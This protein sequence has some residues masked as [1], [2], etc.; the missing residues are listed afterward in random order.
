[1]TRSKIDGKGP[2]PAHEFNYGYAGHGGQIPMPR[3]SDLQGHSK[4]PAQAV[5]KDCTAS[6]IKHR[7]TQG[8]T[9]K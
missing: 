5:D 1:M 2:G 6:D 4:D 9:K 8:S 3:R 7:V